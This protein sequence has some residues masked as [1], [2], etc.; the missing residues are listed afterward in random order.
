VRVPI[1]IEKQIE[2]EKISAYVVNHL[3][4]VKAYATK[5]GLV[6]IINKL[7]PSEMDVDPGTIFIGMI[8]DTL[9]GRTPLYRLDEFV[10]S[11]DT[12]LLFDRYINPKSFCDYNVGRVIDKAYEIGTIKIFTEIAKNAA[13]TFDIN[14]KHVRFDT[15]SVSVFGDYDLY[16][17]EN[18]SQPFEITYGHSK[19]HRPDLKQFLISMLCVD[20]N[21]PIFGKTEDGNGSDKIINNE[22]LT[23]ISKRMAEHGIKDGASIYIADSAMVTKKN[24][25]T[26]GNVIKFISRLPANYNECD[27]VIKKAIK[28]DKWRDLGVLSSTKPTAKRPAAHYK[29]YESNVMLHGKEYRAV[30]IHSSAHDKRRQ[31]RIDRE[32]AT[33]R[34]TFNS[35]CKAAKKQEFHCRADAK[36]ALKKL[37]EGKSKYYNLDIEIEERPKYGKG[38]PKNGVK[39]LTKMMYGLSAVITENEETVSKLREEVGCF[40]MITNVPGDGDD[41]YDSK[42]ILEAYKNQYGIEQNFGFLKDP[43]IVN[44]IFL[45]RPERIEVLGLVLLLSLLVWR[46]IERSMRQYVEQS[47]EDLPGWK[48]R[49]TER[50]TTFMLTTK[51]RGIMIVKIGNHRQLSKPF[52]DQQK[53]YLLALNVNPRIFVKPGA[54]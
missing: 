39:K 44:S 37:Q 50:P 5:I 38:R 35:I 24:L 52:T 51:F 16:S 30:V 49:R 22:I 6:E 32:L 19:D 13:V 25:K 9:S 53:E 43:A 46:L 3:P 17:N 7:I 12:E 14:C 20:R 33:G 23:D 29:A 34:K 31:K 45:K 40:V 4:I 28:E 48:R 1:E 8:F 27:R 2:R 11:Q 10:E 41:A 15:T 47:G 42:A 21:I 26:I 36:E 18:H 54:G